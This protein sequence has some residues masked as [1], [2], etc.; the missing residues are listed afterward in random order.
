[1]RRTFG[2]SAL[3]IVAI[4]SSSLAQGGAPAKKSAPA[5]TQAAAAAVSWAGLAGSWEGKTTRNNSDS[6]V[7]TLTTTFTAD[8]KIWIKFPNREP[9]ASRLITMGGDS[10]VTE[11]G[12]Y[13]SVTRPGHKATT[14]QTSHVSGDKMWGTFHA[15]FDDGKS[16]DG[17][18]T[19]ARKK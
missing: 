2:S 16:L 18:S 7:T 4:T 5:P 1:M 8:K 9:V 14:R 19:A 3:L 11:A 13:E 15:T 17:K 10:I 6:V 12:P